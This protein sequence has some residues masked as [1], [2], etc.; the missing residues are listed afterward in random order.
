MI[1][2]LTVDIN[3]FAILIENRE[4][5]SLGDKGLEKQNVKLITKWKFFRKYL[6]YKKHWNLCIS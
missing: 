1:I 2:W 3:N 5:G 6:P 4:Q